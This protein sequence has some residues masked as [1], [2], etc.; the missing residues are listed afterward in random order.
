MHPS[1]PKPAS[2]PAS[3]QLQLTGDARL[4]ERAAEA[5]GLDFLGQAFW[6]KYIEFE[7]RVEAHDKTF[8]ILKRLI[9]IPQH[10]YSRYFERFRR[11][12]AD[13]PLETLTDADTLAKTR[14][15]V[16]ASYTDGRQRSELEI[17]RDI[18][19]HIDATYLEINAKTQAET[20][21]RWTYEQNIK[22]PYFHVTE[23]D[24]DQLDNWRKYLD[25]EED[26]GDAARI[27]FLYERCLVSC[28]YYDEFWLRYVRYMYSNGNQEDV[29][30]I[31]VKASCIY[32]PIARPEIRLNWALFEEQLD[33]NGTARKIY[34]AILMEMPDDINTVVQKA[35]FERRHGG[36][37]AAIEVYTNFIESE[38]KRLTWH[39]KGALLAEQAKLLWK[40]KG[41][42]EEA[43][44]L[45]E[46][47]MHSKSYAGVREFWESYLRFELEQPATEAGANGDAEMSGTATSGG[48]QETRV[49]K[50]WAT[51]RQNSG[52]DLEAVREL[53]PLYK[54]FLVERGSGV[55]GGAAREFL[56]L[57]SLLFGPDSL[58]KVPGKSY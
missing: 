25:F 26:E 45:Y 4:F 46:D 13:Q 29:R 51:I 30:I 20:M 38:D 11:L 2:C 52:L 8:G 12:A 14:A 40:V 16:I 36:L 48:E 49:R 54:G 7:D 56:A 58:R 15:E 43:R 39:F 42:P 19:N 21:K 1:H 37:G 3:W 28:A 22:R 23:L 9:H 53:S 44:K 34:E 41:A 50:V 57:D 32:A 31:F 18:R 17:E 55:A 33:N 5:V 10:Q 35:N 6:D 24:E 27:V 47:K